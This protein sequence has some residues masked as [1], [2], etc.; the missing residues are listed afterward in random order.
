MLLDTG[1]ELGEVV[2]ESLAAVDEE[3]ARRIE[4]LRPGIKA[5]ETVSKYFQETRADGRLT[6][7][8]LVRLAD[9]PYGTARRTL[10]M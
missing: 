5:I 3:A 2:S 1:R 4:E 7:R 10:R 6:V 8:E 9:V